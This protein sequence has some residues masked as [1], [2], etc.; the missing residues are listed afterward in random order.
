MA[1]IIDRNNVPSHLFSIPELDF[2]EDLFAEP[3]IGPWFRLGARTINRKPDERG[4]ENAVLRKSL[5]L[6]PDGF[7]EIFGNLTFI[8]NAIDHLGKPG[9][10]LIHKDENRSAS[11]KKC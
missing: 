8:G 2:S 4:V 3:L 7:A 9:G 6:P 10:S 1:P 5:L 11:D